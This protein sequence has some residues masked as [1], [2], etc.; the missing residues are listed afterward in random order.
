MFM[1]Q[2]TKILLCAWVLWTMQGRVVDGGLEVPNPER[3]SAVSAHADKR[4]CMVELG[5]A[6]K[7]YN[8]LLY[9]HATGVAA[10]CLPDTVRP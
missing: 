7:L 2:L 1:R 8:G 3:W 10:K 4:E 9:N 5:P 6:Y